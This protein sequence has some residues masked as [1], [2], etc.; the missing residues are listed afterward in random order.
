M[1]GTLGSGKSHFFASEIVRQSL[2][3][4]GLRAV[5][6]R[7][8]QKSLKQSVKQLIE[9]KINKFGV[10][11]MF[12][13]LE[14]EI[15]TPG[16]G[17]IIFQGMQSHTATSIKS[18][19]GFDIAWVEEAQSLS[20]RS[21]DMLRPT[22]R[23]EGSEIWFSWN[24]DRSDDPVD[25]FL[26]VECPSGSI[27]V[28]ANWNDNPW[29]PKE[30]RDE[31]ELDKRDP[32][33]FAHVWEGDYAR[34]IVGAYY[35]DS[36]RQAEHEGRIKKLELDPVLPLKASW[37][38]GVS[39][40]TSIWVAQWVGGQ[41]NFVDYIE[42]EGQPLG[43]Y[44]NELKA[45][46]FG[47]AVCILPHDGAH[48]D[49]LTAIRFEDHVKAAGF[50]TE[51]VRNQGRGAAMQRVEAGRR[52]FPR[53]W[54][55]KDK[56]EAGRIALAS[57]HEN[58]DEQRGIGLGPV[59]DWSSHCFIGSTRVLTRYGSIPISDLPKTG[60]VLTRCGWKEYRN[61]RVTR[62]AAPLVEVRFADGLTV[63]CTPD[64]LFATESGWK[65]AESL[66][67]GMLIQSSLT[68]SHNI[69]M[70]VSTA[71]G[72]LRNTYRGVV[73]SCIGTFGKAHSDKS[74]KDVISTIRMGIL[75]I[76][77]SKILSALR[78][79]NIL[80]RLGSDP[81]QVCL[82]TNIS[83]SAHDARPQSGIN[84]K[85]GVCGI[86]GTLNA[87][88]AGQNGSESQKTAQIVGKC[89][90]LS[91]VRAGTRKS[92]AGLLARSLH[93]ARGKANG[94]LLIE[95]VKKL[96]ETDD[97]WCLT[98]PDVSEFSLENGAVVHNCADAFG[99]MAVSYRE[100][101]NTLQNMKKRPKDWVV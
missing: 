97:V 63:K 16:N 28:R 50:R 10:E 83:R 27:V 74:Q 2:L 60:E 64:H 20:Q 56:T 58:R 6:I 8:V 55:D 26:R 86:G 66:Q 21:L 13:C 22:I 42:G 14:A 18:L 94:P 70:A 47:E 54:F 17:L 52:W 75:Q 46:G 92:I 85:K 31:M 61:P 99:L 15:R 37:D 35:A 19:E 12:E 73:R 7:E 29:L 98:V 49:N 9:D 89:S 81:S 41:I 25:K 3:R 72:R 45:R 101:S 51:I 30:L 23:K 79:P 4:P 11:S 59:H 80:E 53:M 71:C 33:K 48:R 95:R 82:A 68:R 5:C 65:S 44:L 38:L 76:M 69:L 96:N 40:A 24:P 62:N 90:T 39:D 78:L 57:Y 36:L 1:G 43:Y 91:F 34:A 88:K 67:K 32:D 77:R 84:Q 93:I 87:R 100:P